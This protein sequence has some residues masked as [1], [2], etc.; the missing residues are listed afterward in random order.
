MLCFRTIP[1]DPRF[2]VT[3]H[4]I[5]IL[6]VK[7]HPGSQSDIHLMVL[8]SDNNLRYCE[9]GLINFINYPYLF[10]LALGKIHHR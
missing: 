8:T 9:A 4:K 5:K 2:Y 3:H 7:W 6:D 1:I 10:L